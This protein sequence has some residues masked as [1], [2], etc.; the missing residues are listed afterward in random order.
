MGRL[1][2]KVCLITG[3]GSGIGQASARLFA[4]E[5][6]TVVVADIDLRAARATVAGIVKAKGKAV[7][8]QVDGADEAQTVGLVA[9]VVKRLKRIDVLF[10]NA[11]ISGV[12]E[13][14]GP[15]PELFDAVMRVNVRGVCLVS[16]A[17]VPQ[18]IKQRSGSIINMS[19]CIAD[20]G[21]ACRVSH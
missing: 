8:E 11:G 3:A 14:L 1:K 10:N 4:K 9:R 13:V 19:S 12:G 20:I 18:M 17:V 6:A 16:R 15:E 21:R 2:G 5:G 7:A